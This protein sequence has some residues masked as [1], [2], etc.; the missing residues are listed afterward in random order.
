MRIAVRC[1][2]VVFVGLGAAASG[3]HPPAAR[4]VW[5]P[6]HRLLIDAR[7]VLDEDLAAGGRIQD[8]PLPPD[9]IWVSSRPE[10]LYALVAVPPADGTPAHLEVK[11]HL[12]G[13]E[14]WDA[15]AVLPPGLNGVRAAL[16][17]S[18]GRLFLVPNGAFLQV[19]GANRQDLRSWAPFLIVGRDAQGEWTLYQKVDLGW[20]LPFDVPTGADGKPNWS[21]VTHRYDFLSSAR[22]E[23]PDLQDRLFELE[24]GWALVDRHH[25]MVWVFDARGRVKTS[26]TLYETFK[27]KDL[28]L[29]LASFPTAVLACEAAPGGKLILALRNEVAFFYARKTWPVN[30]DP[31]DPAAIGSDLLRQAQAAKDFPEIV[32]KEVDTRSGD[33]RTLQSPAGLPTTYVF[34]P[35]DPNWHFRFAVTAEGDIKSPSEPAAQAAG[36]L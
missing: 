22:I 27:E 29:P 3:P 9:T 17:T 7:Q 8:T 23:T 6:G 2:M 15:Y 33:V 24:E 34:R 5:L 12:A 21:K 16:P 14:I 36:K 25:G 18:D 1:C 19:P 20:G 13:A 35:E 32:W 28:D 10:G 30:T 11:R 26:I 31:G 4:V